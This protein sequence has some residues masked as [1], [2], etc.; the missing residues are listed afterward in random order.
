MI[1]Y[2]SIKFRALKEYC[3]PQGPDISSAKPVEF[4]LAGSKVSFLAPKH[5]TQ[6]TSADNVTP[7]GSYNIDIDYSKRYSH[8]VVDQDSWRYIPLC[9]RS[10]SFYGAW[11][12]GAIA[13]LNM[14]VSVIMPSAPDNKSSLFNPRAFEYSI[15]KY[16]EAR[17]KNDISFGGAEWIAPVN[18]NPI[19]GLSV[20]GVTFDVVPNVETD[21]A[22]K[23]MKYFLMPVG[24]FQILEFSFG[25]DQ[26]MPGN[27]SDKDKKID[28]SSMEELVRHIVRSVNI[29]LSKEALLQQDLALEGMIDRDLVSE[30]PPIKFTTADQDAEWSEYQ[31]LHSNKALA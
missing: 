21:N 17:Y 24:D 26:I 25:L 8:G 4:T 18:W 19:N 20:A 13:E 27:L 10:W 29:D 3:T 23:Y 2:S 12:V 30:F 11:F 16:L 22:G 6:Y 9:N 14:S 7:V 15:S 1:K 28:R 5:K 31:R